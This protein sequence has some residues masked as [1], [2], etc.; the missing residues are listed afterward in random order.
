MTTNS[1]QICTRC[2]MDNVADNSI[3]FADDGTCNYCNDAL[4]RRESEYF[5]NEQGE[6]MLNQ[7]MEQIKADGKTRDFD[8]L[9]GVSG[10]VDSSYL[11]YMGYQFGLRI[12]AVHIDDGFDTYT[13]TQNIDKLCKKAKVELISVQPDLE[14]YKDLTRSFY[15]ARV[16]YITVPQ[17]NLLFKALNDTLKKYKINY[18][19]DGGNF[20]TESI[21]EK[22]LLVNCL[23]KKHIYAI[24]KQFGKGPIDK[25]NLMSFYERYIYDRYFRKAKKVRPLNYIDYNQ[26]KVLEALAEFCGYEYYGAKHYES[27]LTR[28]MQCYYLPERYNMDIRKSHLSS[29]VISGQI[30][31]EEALE[32]LA[33]SP[34]TSQQLMEEDFSFMMNFLEMTKEEFEAVLAQPPL[35]HTDYK[36]S[37]IQNF[38][39]VAR[40][41]RRYLG[42]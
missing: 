12:L 11:L 16:P 33:Q 37:A 2:V 15:L 28:F 19:I 36:M 26:N 32:K 5:P 4:S 6:R 34:Y 3:R 10:G 24:H 25:L 18:S 42:E 1:N 27:I 23:D 9:I 31:R 39:G 40:K 7:L 22:G 20:S 14:Q 41:F 38:A 8:C 21:L 13:A 30:S 29:L 17:D 35:L